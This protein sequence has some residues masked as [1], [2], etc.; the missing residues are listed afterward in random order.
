MK[1]LF[2]LLALLSSGAVQA[3]PVTI[4]FEGVVADDGSLILDP[5]YQ[6]SGFLIEATQFAGIEGKD[7]SLNPLDS[8]ALFWCGVYEPSFVDCLGDEV[9]LSHEDS[10]FSLQSFDVAVSPSQIQGTA[11]TIIVLEG[12][13]AGGGVLQESIEFG[14]GL[15]SI[16]LG[17]EWSDLESVS[18]SARVSI[19]GNGNTL[20]SFSPVID[21]IVVTAVPAPAAVWLFGSALAGLGW[22]RRKQTV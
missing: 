19:S 8:A 6:D 17:S 3:A 10:V 20:L 5:D 1:K 22:M 21:N 18:F 4:D 2:A 7:S 16:V 12:K 13:T 15:Q 11:D 9:T 14:L